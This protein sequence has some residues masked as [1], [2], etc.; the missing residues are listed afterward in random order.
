MPHLAQA[1]DRVGGHP[2]KIDQDGDDEL[3]AAR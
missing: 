2:N 1:W 3:C